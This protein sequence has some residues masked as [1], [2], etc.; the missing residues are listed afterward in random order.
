MNAKITVSGWL[1]SAD[2]SDEKHFFGACKKAIFQ[3]LTYVHEKR[4]AAY[5]LLFSYLF[6]FCL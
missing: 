4:H 6:F 1:S 5:L 3:R 2:F